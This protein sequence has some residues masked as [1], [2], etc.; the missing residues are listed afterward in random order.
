MVGSSLC[1]AFLLRC[2]RLSALSGFSCQGRSAMDI[3]VGDWFTI[4]GP[5]SEDGSTWFYR[6]D[7]RDKT[8]WG[9]QPRAYSSWPD[10][11]ASERIDKKNLCINFDA[12]FLASEI[13]TCRL[14]FLRRDRQNTPPTP[15][16]GPASNRPLPLSD[17]W[18]WDDYKTARCHI[19]H[20]LMMPGEFVYINLWK[21]GVDLAMKCD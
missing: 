19:Q 8:R 14:W 16:T 12:V 10:D 15:A 21:T 6:Q 3:N 18:A 13:R 4:C 17:D 20:N 7:E 1:S 5:P 2:Q 9:W 11:N